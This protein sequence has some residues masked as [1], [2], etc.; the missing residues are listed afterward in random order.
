[1]AGLDEATLLAAKAPGFGVTDTEPSSFDPVRLR[2]ERLGRLRAMM[3]SQGY[4]AVVLFDPNNQRYATGSRYRF[5]YFLRISTRYF[6]VPV[7]GPI[8]L[9]EYPQSGHVSEVLETVGEVRDSKVVWSS[10]RGADEDTAGPF[11]DEI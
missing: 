6:F 2:A 4:A 3:R 8:V 5:G 9:F 10:V 1:I 7:D 11:A